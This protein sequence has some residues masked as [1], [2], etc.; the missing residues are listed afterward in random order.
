MKR[1]GSH[2]R[3]FYRLVAA[4]TRYQR[5]GRFLEILGYYD[6]MVKPFK[7][8]VDRE[9]VITWLK[10]GAQMSETAEGLL[11]RE[12][13]VQAYN[14]E[15]QNSGKTVSAAPAGGEGEAHAE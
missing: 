14:V 5:D 6:P 13:I 7:F 15:K 4:D 10:N 2:K 1:M 8:V 11:R 12:G 9:K 3:P